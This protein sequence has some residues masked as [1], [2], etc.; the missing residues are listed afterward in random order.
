MF[1]RYNKIRQQIL[2]PVRSLGFA[3]L[4]SVCIA[5]V[6][7]AEEGEK[8]DYISMGGVAYTESCQSGGLVLQSVNDTYRLFGYRTSL[9]DKHFNTETI[10][11]N[12]D[13]SVN[14]LELG[15]GKWCA[16]S[17]SNAGFEIDFLALFSGDEDASP[18]RI[19]FFG[20]EP[21]CRFLVKPC[22]CEEGE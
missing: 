22:N 14:S 15:T 1:V 3:L 18:N 6:G 12:P 4:L 21:Y 11:L 7:H 13:C 20:Q 8:L 5:S 10:V 2:H 9:R 19:S 16:N 17:G